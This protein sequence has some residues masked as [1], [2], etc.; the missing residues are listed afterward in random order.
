MNRK[1]NL[2]SIYLIIIKDIVYLYF[3]LYELLFTPLSGGSVGVVWSFLNRLELFMY[4]L[5]TIGSAAELEP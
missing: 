1:S 3:F 2:L 4:C 5:P